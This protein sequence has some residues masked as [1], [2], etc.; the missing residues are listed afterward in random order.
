M[1]IISELYK[2]TIKVK[3]LGPTPENPK[4]HM[5]YVDRG[6]G[7]KRKTGVTTALGIKDKS[8]PL[9]IWQGEEIAKH[10]FSMV[11]SG[12]ALDHENIIKAVFAPSDIFDKAADLG[13]LVHEWVENYINHKLFPKKF[14]MPEMPEDPN[15]VTGVTSF[16]E[17]EAEHKV[18]Y[19]WAE[20]V[21]Y[22]KKY[23]FIGKG[24]FG[25][26]VDG[27]TCLCDLKTGNAI[28]NSVLAQTAA[29]AMADT[30]ECGVKYEG[31]W[32]IRVSKETPE[33]YQERMDLKNKIK[34]LLGKKERDV[35]PYQ[36]FEAKFL[37]DKKTNM[38]RDYDAFLLHWDLLQ[39]DRETDFW[40][41]KQK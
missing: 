6:D 33:Q 26:I 12:V 40:S 23:D 21:L 20:K 38:K 7:L 25:A 17:W 28:Y 11:E 15:V 34:S 24:D 5:Y 31:R 18:K 29:Y 35:E 27:M 19:L 8:G 13:S 39:W 32:A 1:E 3:F 10:L 30:E 2:G 41:N 37:D 36:V 4:R 14:K 22:S 9:M 16:I